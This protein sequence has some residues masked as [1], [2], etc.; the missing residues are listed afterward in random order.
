MAD[1][2]YDINNTRW[3]SPGAPVGMWQAAG[4]GWELSSG[5][6][7]F[8]SEKVDEYTHRQENIRGEIDEV[9]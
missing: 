7:N 9:N 4:R 1:A 8:C 5:Y 3:T 6:E 2:V